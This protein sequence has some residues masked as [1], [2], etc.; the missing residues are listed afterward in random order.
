M[1]KCWFRKWFFVSVMLLSGCVTTTNQ[2]MV[3]VESAHSKRIELGMK[4]LEV[5]KRDNARFQ[6]S[7]ALLLKKNSADAYQGIAMVHQANGEMKPALEAFKKAMKYA[8]ENNRASIQVAYGR[9]LSENG[10]FAAACPHFEEAAADF[11][12][13]ER[14]DAL[15]F[16]GRCAMQTGNKART[17][18]AFEHALNLNPR[19]P[20]VMIE[21]A[22]IYFQQGEYPKSKR[23]LDQMEKL[24]VPTARSLWL[25]IRIERIFGNKDKEASYA[26]ALKN[27][28]PYSKEY[29][30]Y[31]RLSDNKK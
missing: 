22:D 23:L 10:D 17:I 28:H 14:A 16:A 6:F 8:D 29:L 3:N 2:T 25:G 27:R 11:D 7:K 31:K 20:A 13:P 12:Y 5:D 18:A 15:Y 9:Y 19:M 24:A 1:M 4:Y 30:E 26:V 21:L